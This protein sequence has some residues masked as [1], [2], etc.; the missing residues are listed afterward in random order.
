[1]LQAGEGTPKRGSSRAHAARVL[2][3]CL[4]VGHSPLLFCILPR[5]HFVFL[6]EPKLSFV[7]GSEETASLGRFFLVF[8]HSP[9]GSRLGFFWLQP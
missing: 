5:D 6:D 9:S 8:I 7:H 3:P 4:R 2:R 1:M